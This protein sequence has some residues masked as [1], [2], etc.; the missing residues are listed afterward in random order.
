MIKEWGKK[1]KTVP[2]DF[3]LLPKADLETAWVSYFIQD[4]KEKTG[5]PPFR[6][7]RRIYDIP[8]AQQQRFSKYFKLMDYLIELG[9]KNGIITD[10]NEEG[11]SWYTIRYGC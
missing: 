6:I 11:S 2:E 1:A 10:Q 4:E 5:L 9:M 3:V 7:V 8:K